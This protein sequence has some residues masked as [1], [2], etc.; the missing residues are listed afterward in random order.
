MGGNLTLTTVCHELGRETAFVIGPSE[1]TYG[2][3]IS[4]EFIGGDLHGPDVKQWRFTVWT[5]EAKTRTSC[6]ANSSTYITL[7]WTM[8]M[9]WGILYDQEVA[10]TT[11]TAYVH[12]RTVARIL[13]NRQKAGSDASSNGKVYDIPFTSYG[14]WDDRPY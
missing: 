4:C 9:V 10:R 5:V 6:L 11:R 14:E 2:P 8:T 7:T 3:V 1:N 12:P 13:R